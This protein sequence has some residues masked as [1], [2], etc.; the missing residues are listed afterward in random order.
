M[1]LVDTADNDIQL[2]LQVDSFGN[3]QLVAMN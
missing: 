2:V 3:S 1:A